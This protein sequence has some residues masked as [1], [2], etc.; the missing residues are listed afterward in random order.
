MEANFFRFLV[1]DERFHLEGRRIEKI[2]APLPG[3]WTIKIGSRHHLICVSGK[4]QHAL[5]FSPHKPSNPSNPPAFL[6]WWRKRVQGRRIVVCRTDWP[7]RRLA[8]GLDT[9][10]GQWMILDVQSGISLVQNLEEDFGQEP[11]WPSWEQITGNPLIFHQFPQITP[12]LRHTLSVMD[13]RIGR[14]L[15]DYL[16]RASKPST[17]NWAKSRSNTGQDWLIPWI[18]PDQLRNRFWQILSYSDP[19]QAAEDHGFSILES[20]E[21]A[22]SETQSHPPREKRRLTKQLAKIAADEERLQ[23]MVSRREEAELIKNN[24]Y[25]LNAEAHVERLELFDPQGRNRVLNL[26]PRITVRENMERLFKQAR[27]GRRGLEHVAR[28]R[29]ETQT[30][31]AALEAGNESPASNCPGPEKAGASQPQVTKKAKS[32]TASKDLLMY[33]SSDGFSIWRGKNS[34]GNHRLVTR[35]A[36]PHDLW[37]HAAHGPGAHVLVRRPG[38]TTEIPATTL[39]EAAGIAAL[40]SHFSGSAK[41][42]IICALA[43]HVSPIKGGRP[44]QVKVREISETMLVTLDPA[45]EERLKLK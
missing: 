30:S 7:S 33:A 42:E 23:G 37:F 4:R 32:H 38:P 34:Q 5:F 13:P 19:L 28:R 3:A 36:Q 1:Q 40:R 17:V 11:E 43:K 25:Q 21:R 45:L 29:Q 35:V 26:D 16:Q 44:G 9:S 41:A 27:K 31:L 8:L 2:Y 20:L 12:P 22:R 14:D 10:P 39:Q 24:L 6:G 15:L 18:V